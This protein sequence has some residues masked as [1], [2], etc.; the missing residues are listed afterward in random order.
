MAKNEKTLTERIKDV[1]KNDIENNGAWVEWDN[2]G[3]LKVFRPNGAGSLFVPENMTEGTV[4]VAEF[5][6]KNANKFMIERN[7]KRVNASS[8]VLPK[9]VENAPKGTKLA[10]IVAEIYAENAEASER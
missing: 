6:G 4:K 10:A 2:Q 8:A 3:N 1:L 9:L 5:S 7:F